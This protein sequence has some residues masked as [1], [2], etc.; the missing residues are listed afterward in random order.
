LRTPGVLG[1]FDD[2]EDE[3]ESLV[4]FLERLDLDEEEEAGK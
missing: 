4:L 1:F 3:E 2:E